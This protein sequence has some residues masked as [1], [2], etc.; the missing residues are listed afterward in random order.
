MW[1]LYIKTQPPFSIERFKKCSSSKH[2]G[3]PQLGYTKIKDTCHNIIG[4]EASMYSQ[5]EL[6]NRPYLTEYTSSLK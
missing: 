4:C 5:D 1:S 6:V 3:K 2:Y